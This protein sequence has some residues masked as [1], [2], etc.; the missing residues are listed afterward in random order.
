ML[1]AEVTT[2]MELAQELGRPMEVI[3]ELWSRMP[4]DDEA[5]AIELQTKRPQV[6][7]WRFRAL[8]RLKKSLLPSA[9]EK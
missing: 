6:Y 8:Q 5:I 7:K 3:V 2:L 9:P 4:M 1:E